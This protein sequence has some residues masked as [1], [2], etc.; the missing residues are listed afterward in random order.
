MQ[1]QLLSYTV[2]KFRP[3]YVLGA[4]QTLFL[5]DLASTREPE[6]A[7]TV[8]KLRFVVE[9]LEMETLLFSCTISSAWFATRH[10]DF[11]SFI[12]YRLANESDAMGRLYK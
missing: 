11:T 4:V 8:L 2:L 7:P 5:E 9:L 12:R 3:A 1:I 6:V 10:A